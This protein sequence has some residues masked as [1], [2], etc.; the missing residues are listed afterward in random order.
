MIE[1]FIRTVR[2]LPSP[3]SFPPLLY[4]A[5]QE[6]IAVCRKR[7]AELEME[8]DDACAKREAAKTQLFM[9]GRVSRPAATT[10]DGF[11]SILGDGRTI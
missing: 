6:R 8:I 3:S 7:L 11:F 2:T 1:Q 5:N 10:D 4:T 9:L